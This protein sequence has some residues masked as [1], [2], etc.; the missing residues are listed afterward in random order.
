MSLKSA[1]FEIKAELVNSQQEV[2]DEAFVQELETKYK[3]SAG[4]L[5]FFYNNLL[6]FHM[7]NIKN[8]HSDDSKKVNRKWTKNEVEFMF[9]YIN[10]RQEEGGLNITEIL[11][12]V[13]QLLDRGYQSV[14]YKYYALIKAKDKKA[15]QN[16]QEPLQFTTIQQDQMP[17]IST[18]MIEKPSIGMERDLN[19]R[20]TEE[21][22]SQTP[23]VN[24]DD[25][26]DILSGLISNVQRLPGINLNEL[27]KTLYQLTNMAL[28]NQN[29]AQQLESVKSEINFEK[30]ALR[31]KLVKQ[32]QKLNAEKRR[33]DELQSEVAKLAREISAFNKLEDT[34]KIQNL[35]S[36]NQRLN[37]LIDNFG[38]VLQVGS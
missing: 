7:N 21:S 12:E 8:S 19:Q 17:V 28:L 2:T 23:S 29:A 13:A 22:H 34:A 32:E 11:E 38:V 20:A 35:K 18:E 24:N 26:L 15:K 37:Y 10:E 9:Q 36:Y 3:L 30:Q 4:R 33:N 16:K 6:M 1:V 25:L 14:N 27:L 31:E 5:V